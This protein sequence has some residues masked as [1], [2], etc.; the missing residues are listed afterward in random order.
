[1]IYLGRAE[2]DGLPLMVGSSDG[3][4]YRGRKCFGVS[5]FEFRLPGGDSS[6]RFVGFAK[7]PGWSDGSE[8]VGAEEN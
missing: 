3:R 7:I 5:V 8:V 1:M 6:S 4:S 2:S